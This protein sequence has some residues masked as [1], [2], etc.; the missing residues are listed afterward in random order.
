MARTKLCRKCKMEI[1]KGASKCPHCQSNQTSPV[2]TLLAIIIVIGGVWLFFGNRNKSNTSTSNSSSSSQT[3]VTKSELEQE[4]EEK[5]YVWGNESLGLAI[6]KKTNCQT[7]KTLTKITG[8]VYNA[9]RTNYSYVQ[10]VFAL[11]DENGMKVGDAWGNVAGLNSG[12]SWKFEA[13]YLGKC[14]EYKLTDV[15]AY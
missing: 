2:I 5:G 11:Y 15:S 14:S 4:M 3:A 1:P 9:S 7:S 6:A 13:S 8:V 10:V 12:E